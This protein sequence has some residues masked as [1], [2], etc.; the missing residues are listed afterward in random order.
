MP[1]ERG[2]KNDNY[3]RLPAPVITAGREA[4]TGWN[5][6][7]ASQRPLPDFLIIGAQ[8]SGT[9]SLYRYLLEHPQVMPATPSKEIGRASCRE[10]V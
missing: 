7:T 1:R 3:S 8:R 2:S 10:R 9:T 4:V 5:M 6:L